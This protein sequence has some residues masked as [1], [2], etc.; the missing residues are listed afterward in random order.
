[1]FS[2][3]DKFGRKPPCGPFEVPDGFRVYAV[4]DIHGRADLLQRLHGAVAEDSRVQPAENNLIVYLGDYLDRGFHVRE[5]LDEL[6]TGPPEGFRARYLRGNHEQLFLDFLKDPSVLRLWLDLGG[7]ATLMSY[8][9]RP[10]SGF[11]LRPGLA[12][13]VRRELLEAMPGDHIAFLNSLE[14]FFHFGDY[15][16]VHAGIRPGIPGELQRPEDLYW[17]RDDFLFSSEDFGFRVV[18]GHTIDEQAREHPNRVGIDTG[19]YATGVLT[20][21]VLEGGRLRY[22]STTPD[23]KG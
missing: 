12:A 7:Q 3:L 6:V 5:T 17:I 16:F 20:C 11:G 21:A 15:F 18:H 23:G 4:G 8:G 2:F 13:E 9:I 22:L 19:A 1:M 10:P 14:P